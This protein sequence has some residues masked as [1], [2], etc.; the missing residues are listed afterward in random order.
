MCPKSRHGCRNRAMIALKPY[1]PS[2]SFS[3]IAPR[4]TKSYHDFSGRTKPSFWSQN[5]G[6][7]Q[8]I[9]PRFLAYSTTR[10]S[11]HTSRYLILPQ[12]LGTK[13]LAFVSLLRLLESSFYSLFLY[14]Q[15]LD[16]SL[17]FLAV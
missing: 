4:H 9:A 11:F 10:F 14:F 12:N 16:N 13:F 3:K 17:V 5:R 2:R 15:S 6:T 1:N 8:K 7:P